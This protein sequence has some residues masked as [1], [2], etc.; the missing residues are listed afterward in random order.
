M[1]LS[2]APMGISESA[3]KLRFF[4]YAKSCIISW[5]D[6]LVAMAKYYIEDLT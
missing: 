6:P 1:D 4:A 3:L 2:V 5:A